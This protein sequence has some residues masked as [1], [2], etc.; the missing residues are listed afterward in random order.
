MYRDVPFK[1]QPMEWIEQDLQEIASIEPNAT[2][3]QLL[4]A[5]P[6]A[7]TYT[8]ASTMTALTATIRLFC[9]AISERIC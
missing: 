2:T 6:L 3:I 8:P 4:S 1:M 7:M 9:T 5:N